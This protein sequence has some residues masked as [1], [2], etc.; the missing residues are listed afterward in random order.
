M[1]ETCFI[2]L[3]GVGAAFEAKLAAAGIRTWSDALNLPLPFSPARARALREGIRES[4]ERL[5]AGDVRWFGDAL[6][7]AAQWRLFPHFRSKAAYVDIETTGLS[8]SEDCI[9]TIALYDG[10][11]VRTYVQGVNLEAFADDILPYALLVTWNGRGFDAPLLRR[12]LRI[13]LDR[14]DMGHL[15]LLPVF[16]ALGLRGGLKN[17]EKRLGLGRGDLDGVDGWAAVRLWREYESARDPRVLETLLAYNVA[18]VLSLEVL[19]EYAVARCAADCR[20][21]GTGKTA[22]AGGGALFSMAEPLAVKAERN[23]FTPDRRVLRRLGL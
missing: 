23:P 8:W 5:A 3:P 20:D 10:H 18:D 4:R 19:A 7:P 1:L 2:H 21:A 12:G 16:R 22:A 6:P 11:C 9:T 17:V 14:G 15:D 13:P